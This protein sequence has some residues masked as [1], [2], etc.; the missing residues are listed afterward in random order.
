MRV[1]PIK[2]ILVHTGMLPCPVPSWS[3]VLQI[4]IS[5]RSRSDLVLDADHALD[6]YPPSFY[7]RVS[8]FVVF[9]TNVAHLCFLHCS[10]RNV[11]AHM[12]PTKT[13]K[14]RIPCSSKHEGGFARWGLYRHEFMQVCVEW[15]RMRHGQ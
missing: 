2:E 15:A 9:Q 7:K 5:F 1:A 13:L 3:H 6:F 11:V 10:H 12:F 14:P 4:C 8:R